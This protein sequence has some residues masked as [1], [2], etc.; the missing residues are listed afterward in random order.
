MNSDSG[1][2]LPTSEPEAT[3]DSGAIVEVLPT[4]DSGAIIE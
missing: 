4:T 3:T 2:I 1:S